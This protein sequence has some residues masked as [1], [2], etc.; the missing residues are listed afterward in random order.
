MTGLAP[1]AAGGLLTLAEFAFSFGKRDVDSGNGLLGVLA[2]AVAAGLG[3][4]TVSAL[5]LLAATANVARTLP[6]TVAGTAAA[7]IVVALLSRVARR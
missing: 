2:R 5:V 6:M 3:G 7:V 1:L 4:I